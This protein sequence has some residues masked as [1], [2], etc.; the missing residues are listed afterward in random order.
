MQYF[1]VLVHGEI[2]Y[3]QKTF[4]QNDAQ[5]G[6]FYTTVGSICHLA[7]L[8]RIMPNLVGKLISQQNITNI[9]QQL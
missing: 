3:T 6:Q 1:Y 2:S 5:L 8:S 9:T 4:G 7:V